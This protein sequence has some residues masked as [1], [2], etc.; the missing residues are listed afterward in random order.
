MKIIDLNHVQDNA[1]LEADLCIVGSG[2]AGLSL[3]N[4]F[5]GTDIR[6]LVLESGGLTD[7]PE[8]DAL[9]EI[10]STGWLR[11]KNQSKI[12]RRI[13]GGSSH[14]WTG[15]CVPF[16]P[17][18][19]ER[20]S[21]M[22][23]TGWPVSYQSY[24][25]YFERAGKYL[26]LGPDRY[27]ESLWESFKVDPPQ[28]PLGNPSLE[29]RF[30]QFS[31][32]SMNR[33]SM[34]FGQDW[35]DADAPNI[36]ILLHAN[37]T[38]INLNSDG[39]CFDSV[40]VATLKGKRRRVKAG[41]MALCA[42]G[43]D[44]ARLLLASNRVYSEGV[45]NRYDTVGRFL[46]DHIS[47]AAGD[48]DPKNAYEVRS[49]FGGYWL[50][51][52]NGRHRFLHGLGLSPEAQEKDRLVNCDAYLDEG[53][54]GGED[55]W[56]AFKRLTS[57]RGFSRQDAGVL[58]RN[59]GEIGGGL[60]RR[61]VKHRP[62][63]GPVKKVNLELIL[64]QVPD[65]ESRVTL[66]ADKKDA[67]GMPLSSLHWKVS[68]T[69]RRTA[70]RIVELICQ[71]FD[72]LGLPAPHNVPQF[73]ENSLFYERYHP[74]GTTRMSSSPRTGVVDENCQVHGVNG[75]FVSGSSVFPTAGSANPTLMIVATAVRLADHLKSRH[76][77][78]SPVFVEAE[79]EVEAV[80]V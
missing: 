60:Y 67:L 40:D 38:H 17:I 72:R 41:A 30:W 9:Y 52:A 28:P 5:V 12:R 36:Q 74:T 8:T 57:R 77:E 31:K 3:A 6:V 69:E 42:G 19:F 45:G 7:E 55:P 66:S 48:F 33:D 51:D 11:E 61:S 43:I 62:E 56:G 13:L 26:G 50:D 58:L 29:P 75:L 37:V 63:L 2:P 25:P 47:I 4:E 35:V 80:A 20:R 1:F 64:E 54:P 65:P 70:K 53:M 73:D 59:L 46:M 22:P 16:Q 78:P 76:L 21:W 27:D 34:R 44:N 24:E 15:R 14:I 18:D 32:R 10:E 68:D 71:E 23:Y 79:A 39:T 49:R